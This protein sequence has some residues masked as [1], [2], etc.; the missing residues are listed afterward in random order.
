MNWT[1][2]IGIFAKPLG[3]VINKGLAMASTAFVTWA[4]AKGLPLDS[5]SALAGMV[6][7]GLSTLVSG[8]AATQGVQIPVINADDTNGVKV[9]SANSPSPAVDAPL[10]VTPAKA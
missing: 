4:V 1:S 8:F 3:A 6:V 9:V 2:I 10:A 5:A 7:M